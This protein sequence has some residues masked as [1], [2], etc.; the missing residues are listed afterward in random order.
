[1]PAEQ[2]SRFVFHSA[3]RLLQVGG[4]RSRFVQTSLG[5]VHYYHAKGNGPLLPMVFVH[6][7]G[8]HAA[9]LYPLFKRLRRYCQEI[10]AVDLPAH[11]WSETPAQ[12]TSATLN[13]MFCEALDQILRK[14]PPALLFGNSL[15]GLGV[16]RYC[17]HRPE[18]IKQLVLSS[19]GGAALSAEQLQQ[20]HGIFAHETQQQPSA[21]L[22]RL[23]NQ[24]P[25]LGWL[26]AKE[27]QLRFRKPGLQAVIQQFNPEHLLTPE[28]LQHLTVPTLMIWGQQDRILENQVHFFRAHLPEHVRILEPRHFTHCPYMEM[29]DDLALQIR[30]FARLHHDTELLGQAS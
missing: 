23:Y 6:G 21:F 1:M 12:V 10:I 14:S 28:D 11:G 9:D 25:A 13:Q 7:M 27:V 5:K 20:L 4:Y 26:V 18:R 8:A 22:A 17:R 15:G 29:P 3:R 2:L 16:I 30:S 24:P 19:P